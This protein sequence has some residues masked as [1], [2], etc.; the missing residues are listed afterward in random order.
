MSSP[1]HEF[2]LPLLQKTLN[3]G[4]IPPQKIEKTI[5]NGIRVIRSPGK[6]DFDIA[7]PVTQYSEYNVSG[8]QMLYA[9]RYQ[10]DALTGFNHG[11]YGWPGARTV[12]DARREPGSFAKTDDRVK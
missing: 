11:Q 12:D 5:S 6:N 2:G 10:R 3:V 1:A 9:G 7:A 4:P 8:T